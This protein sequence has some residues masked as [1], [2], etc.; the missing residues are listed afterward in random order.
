MAT[1]QQRL[2]SLRTGSNMNQEELG[3]KIGVGKMTIS[4]YETGKRRPDIETLEALADIFNV[5]TDYLLG[6]TDVT[7][8][9]LDEEDLKILRDQPLRRLIE[10]YKRLTPEGADKLL[11]YYNDLNPRYFKKDGEES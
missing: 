9:I 5:S 8:Q 10:Y 3:E 6:K 7:I 2:K 1:F 4:Q 11:E